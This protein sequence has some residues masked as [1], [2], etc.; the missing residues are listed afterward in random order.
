MAYSPNQLQLTHVLQQLYRRLGGVV[1]L[2][3]DG[4]QSV[5][6]DSKLAEQLG[7]GNIDDFLNGGTLIVVDTTDNAAP[8]GEF[9]YISDYDSTSMSISLSPDLTDAIE[10]GDRIM[11]IGA[12]FPLYDMTEVVNDALKYLGEIPVPDTS[13]TTAAEQTEYT[14]PAVVVGKQLLDVEVQGQLG[15]S[16]NNLFIPV[17]NWKAVPPASMG[18]NGTLVLPQLAA[19]YQVRLTYL[20]IHPRVEAYDDNISQFLHPDIVHACVFAHAV[21]WKNDQNA[22]QGAPDN[23][24]IA[25]E[26]KAWSQF[27]RARILHP[28]TIAPR[29]IQGMPH[30][31]PNSINR[32][33][34]NPPYQ[35]YG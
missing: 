31:T 20:G 4:T 19:G 1:T 22:V 25:L 7:E 21:Q 11:F 15:D 29:R 10:A 28:I 6:V 35:W 13:I 12:D 14:L 26:Q 34:L 17:Q 32:S 23:A 3:T 33:A 18:G 24:L 2:A 30:W 5:A 27:D 16:D 8:E 9:S